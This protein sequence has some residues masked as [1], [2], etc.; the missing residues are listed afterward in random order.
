MAEN[1]ARR[2]YACDAGQFLVLRLDVTHPGMRL[3]R[4]C[5]KLKE[6]HKEDESASSGRRY[7]GDSD[8]R[9]EC[10]REQSRRLTSP[11]RTT[12]EIS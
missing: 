1:A 12:S 6:T 7:L 11:L 4:E 8:L 9:L 3:E 10:Q 2:D 5:A